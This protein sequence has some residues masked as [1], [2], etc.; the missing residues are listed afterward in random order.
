MSIIFSSSAISHLKKC[1]VEHEAN[2][3]R[4]AMVPDGCAGYGYDISFIAKTHDDFLDIQGVKVVIDKSS[5]A[6]LKNLKVDLVTLSLGQKQLVF[7]NPQVQSACGC[8]LS[9]A[10]KK[11]EGG[12]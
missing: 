2:Y 9:V 10:V 1:L 5:Q 3:V 6:L 11:P 7:D 12:E 4:F 8:G